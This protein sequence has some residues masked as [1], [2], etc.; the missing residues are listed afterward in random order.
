MANHGLVDPFGGG[1][2]VI[3]VPFFAQRGRSLGWAE[4]LHQT[5]KLFHVHFVTSFCAIIKGAI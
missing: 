1:Q 3:F 4:G 5:G 2:G